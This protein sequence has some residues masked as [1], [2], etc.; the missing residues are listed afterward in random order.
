[1]KHSFIASP[2]GELLNLPYK[3]LSNTTNAPEAILHLKYVNKRKTPFFLVAFLF[4]FKVCL[5]FCFCY[6]IVTR[7]Q[8]RWRNHI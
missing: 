3:L 1:M 6:F 2:M 4:I 8:L 7:A 5:V